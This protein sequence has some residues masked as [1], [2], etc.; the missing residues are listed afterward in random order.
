MPSGGI[1]ESYGSFIPSFLRNLH[2][3]LHSGHAR[4]SLFS[5][6]S[7]EFIACKFFDDSHSDQCEVIYHYSFDLH[8]CSNK[9]Y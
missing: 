5:T 8:F 3:V 4:G 6:P 7:P 2:T 9:Q 1:V